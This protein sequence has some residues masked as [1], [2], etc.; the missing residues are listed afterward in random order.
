VEDV[1]DHLDTVLTY[2][3]TTPPDGMESPGR[4]YLV[5]EAALRALGDDARADATRAAGRALI[6]ARAEKITDP[7]LR[8]AYTTNVAAHRELLT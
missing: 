6:A 4:V 2:L 1:R 7:A 8:T 3:E 5:C